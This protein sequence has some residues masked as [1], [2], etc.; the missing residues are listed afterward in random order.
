MGWIGIPLIGGVEFSGVNIRVLKL[1]E[2]D[3]NLIQK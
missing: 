1:Q 2:D 3:F